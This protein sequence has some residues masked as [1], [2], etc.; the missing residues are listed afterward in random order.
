MKE[1][2]L[3]PYCKANGLAMNASMLRLMLA[4]SVALS[5]FAVSRMIGI[6][7][8][9]ATSLILLHISRP[10]MTGIITS[11]MIRS[12]MRSVHSLRPLLPLCADTQRYFSP[13]TDSRKRH[14]CI[15]SSTMTTRALSVFLSLL[16]FVATDLEMDCS[17]QGKDMVKVVLWHRMKLRKVEQRTDVYR[18]RYII[19]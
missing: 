6:L 16:F 17:R 8:S 11:A 1:E 3:E 2:D 12:G 18:L 9:G 14:I 10:S 15:L 5:P 4:F 19:V 13:R 7:E